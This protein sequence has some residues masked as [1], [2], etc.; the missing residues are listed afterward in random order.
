MAIT[1][2]P[3]RLPVL[4]LGN[5]IAA[6]ILLGQLGGA[7]IDKVLD[8]LLENLQ[9]QLSRYRHLAG[10]EKERN[11]SKTAG[12]LAYLQGAVVASERAVDIVENCRARM[13]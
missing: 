8:E 7:M 5:F 2:G 11:D 3:S 9:R 12:S 4:G 1:E 6:K 10:C 13:C